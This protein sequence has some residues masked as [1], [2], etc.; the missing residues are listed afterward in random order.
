MLKTSINSKLRFLKINRLQKLFFKTIKIYT[1]T[2]DSGTTSLIG[3]ERRKK[4]DK[5][6]QVLGQIDELNSYLGLVS[7]QRIKTS[8]VQVY[9]Q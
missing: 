1:K 5:I 7:I 8:V 2:G 3:G 6:F 4:T 9:L